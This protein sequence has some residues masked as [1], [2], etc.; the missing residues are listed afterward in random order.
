[1]DLVVHK[2]VQ[3]QHV[4]KADGD[5][6]IERF[7]GAP[8][9][10]S[11]LP[12]MVEAREIKHPFDVGFFRAVEHRRGYR[13]TVPQIAAEL[14]QAILVQRFDGLVV[15]VDLLEN[16]LEWTRVMLRIVSINRLPNLESEAGTCPAKMRL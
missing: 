11:D 1:M 15:A 9:E 13:H 8:V 12:R 16:V 6:A 10:N 7:A 14:H 2:V 5:L 3:L 4:D